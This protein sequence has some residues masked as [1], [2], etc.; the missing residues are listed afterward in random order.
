MVTKKAT[1]TIWG[2]MHRS[3]ATVELG[4]GWD[5]QPAAKAILPTDSG[6]TTALAFDDPMVLRDIAADLLA[7]AKYMEETPREAGV[8]S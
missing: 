8:D 4:H 7:A 5:G 1:E 3:S 6:N 2:A